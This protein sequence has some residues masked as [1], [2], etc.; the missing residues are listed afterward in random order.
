M[1]YYECIVN[2][3]ACG[4]ACRIF[5]AAVAHPVAHFV[6]HG[7]SNFYEIRTEI[8][9]P[10]GG[11]TNIHIGPHNPLGRSPEDVVQGAQFLVQKSNL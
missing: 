11:V 9:N 2:C 6:A 10:A 1:D 3:V 7:N 5:V 8:K 4:V